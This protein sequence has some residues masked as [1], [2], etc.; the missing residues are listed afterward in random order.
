MTWFQPVVIGHCNAGMKAFLRKS[1]DQHDA[2]FIKNAA[3][4]QFAINYVHRLCSG[5][6]AQIGYFH[7]SKL[8]HSCKYHSAHKVGYYCAKE[9]TN[10]ATDR[11]YLTGGGPWC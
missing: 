4:H 2:A 9:V 5:D 10:A 8:L 1:E 11:W 6:H 3:K 7:C